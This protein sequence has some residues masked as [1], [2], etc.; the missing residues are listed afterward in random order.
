MILKVVI[1]DAHWHSPRTR[2][3]FRPSDQLR[4]ELEALKAL[5]R[6]GEHLPGKV[7]TLLSGNLDGD[8]DV[9]WM[10]RT[11]IRSASMAVDNSTLAFRPEFYEQVTPEALVDYILGYQKLT[12]QLR[13]WAAT[14]PHTDQADLT[15]KRTEAGFDNPQAELLP[16]HR[17]LNR[18][19]DE[20]TDWHDQQLDTLV[21]GEVYPPHLFWENGQLVM[22]DWENVGLDHRLHDLATVWIRTFDNPAWQARFHQVVVERG[23]LDQPED[24]ALWDLEIV[25]KAA[26][27]LNYLAWSKTE[28]PK[29][30]AS[31]TLFLQRSLE[32]RLS[33]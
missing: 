17:A 8:Q 27:N 15:S 6:Y 33:Q 26:G 1:D 18:Y 30:R 13:S 28:T 16:Y 32:D 9:A 11:N 21:H 20:R 7:P 5:N 31:M 24:R 2:K 22:I 25:Y 14:T 19:F 10:L 4:A 29:H 3:K 12:P 23:R